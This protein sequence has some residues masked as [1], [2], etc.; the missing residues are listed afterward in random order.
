MDFEGIKDYFRENWKKILIPVAV[1]GI[2]LAIVLGPTFSILPG[3]GSKKGTWYVVFM[4]EKSGQPVDGKLE[5]YYVRE[6]TLF[7]INTTNCNAINISI[8]AVVQKYSADFLYYMFYP[9]N[10]SYLLSTGPVIDTNNQLQGIL[11][12][13]KRTVT[14]TIY[15]DGNETTSISAGLHEIT[16]EFSEEP[17][18]QFTFHQSGCENWSLVTSD[19]TFENANLSATGNILVL[20]SNSPFTIYL[21][22]GDNAIMRNGTGVYYAYILTTTQKTRFMINA[23]ATISVSVLNNVD[24]VDMT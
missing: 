16:V 20:S 22:A 11:V 13:L 12:F 23:T 3:Q 21:Q 15:E 17:R 19:T 7:L 18:Y 24:I 1:V 5:L 10:A 6:N 2:I 9:N 8:T 14:A 4:A